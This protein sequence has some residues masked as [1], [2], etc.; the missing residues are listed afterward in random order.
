[1][2]GFGASR[3]RLDAVVTAGPVFSFSETGNASAFDYLR[4]IIGRGGPR[5]MRVVKEQ[6]APFMY[7]VNRNGRLR[8]RFPEPASR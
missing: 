1:M 8:R 6:P 2:G 5:L 4:A 3:Q 7:G